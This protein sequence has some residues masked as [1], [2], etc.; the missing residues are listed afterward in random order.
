[1][2][3]RKS[4][5][6]SKEDIAPLSSPFNEFLSLIQEGKLPQTE[7]LATAIENIQA[8]LAEWKPTS[9]SDPFAFLFDR[10][11]NS[12]ALC[13]FFFCYCFMLHFIGCSRA[14]VG[15]FSQQLFSFLFLISA[16]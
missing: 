16:L 5:R 11:Y 1:M 12:F 13:D 14:R 3:T 2:A 15:C 10:M 9:A 8:K 7:Q 4:Q 6:R